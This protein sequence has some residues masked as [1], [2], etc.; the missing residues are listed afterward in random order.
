M[1][2]LAF[3]NIIITRLTYTKAARHECLVL[4]YK[5]EKL[6][7]QASKPCMWFNTVT[8][9]SQHIYIYTYRAMRFIMVFFNHFISFS[10]R[11]FAKQTVSHARRRFI[12][13][14]QT[15]RKAIYPATSFSGDGQLV[16]TDRSHQTHH[17]EKVLFF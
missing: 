15:K 4:K 2:I 16:G 1:A 13:L 11:Y 5:H 8:V 17:H 6:D 7:V 10:R 3:H 9:F 12:S 14:I